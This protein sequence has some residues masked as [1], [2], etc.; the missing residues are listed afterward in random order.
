MG[1]HIW[2]PIVRKRYTRI[3]KYH[4]ALAFALLSGGAGSV[5]AQ[6]LPV[7]RVTG[8][9][10]RIT[11]SCRLEIAPD[12]VIADADGNGVIL[13]EANDITVDFADSV[14]RGAD[15]STPWNELT[16]TGVRLDG[17]S[18]VTIRN[19]NVH[20]FKVGVY[21]SKADGLVFEQADLSDNYRAHLGS[22]PERE[23]SSDW[24][25]PHHNE[26]NQWM[27]N[28]GAALYVEESDGITV[29]NVRVRRGQ[30]GIVLDTVAN[31]KVYDNDCSFLSGWGL[32]LWRATGNT[33]TRNAFDFCVRGHVEGVYNRGQ[34][35][36][37]ILMF[38]QVSNNVIA[39][40]SVTHG[41]DGIFGFAGLDA[42]GEQA[43]NRQR[44]RLR[45]E[46]GEQ[47]VDDKI[48][49]SDEVLEA[50]TR[51]GCNGNIF[52]END[53]SYA[54]AHGLEMTFSF[55]N[56]IFRNRFVENA[57]C[58]IWGGFSQ[59][60]LIYENLFDGNGGMAYGLERGG[61]NIEHSA[62][63]MILGNQFT[64]NRAAIHIWWDGLGDFG[65]LPWAKTS[66][67]GVLNNVI[68]DNTFTIN[69]EPRPFY[70][71]GQN[72]KRLAF[73]FRNDGGPFKGTLITNNTFKIDESVGKKMET[74]GDVEILDNGPVPAVQ[75]PSYTVLG[76]SRPVEVRNGVPYSTRSKL[77]GRD[78]IIMDE[79]GPWDHE[80]PLVRQLTKGGGE[81]VYDVLGVSGD[82]KAEAQG[83]GYTVRVEPGKID[84]SQRVVISVDEGVVPYSVHLTGDGLDRT[85]SG[86]T[87]KARWL[88]RAFSWKDKVDPREDFDAWTRLARASDS[89]PF[90]CDSLNLKFSFGGPKDLVNSGEINDTSGHLAQSDIGS[91]YFGIEAVGRLRMPKGTWRVRTV[92]DDGIR[93][94]AMT[95]G[96]GNDLVID[97]WTWHAPTP[98]EGTFTV[99]KD[100]DLV[101]MR[102]YHFEIDGMSMLT[103]DLER[104][105]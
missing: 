31:S 66:Y 36:A 3:M 102:V 61:V 41:G 98:N 87:I 23:D 77:R 50:H 71:L 39:Q 17:H 37:G 97:N 54:P 59:D 42:L 5:Y 72:E 88:A 70:R 74:S 101:V 44:D 94:Y 26:D 86:T 51:A 19:A 28:Y 20:G 75:V 16:G 18:N 78:Q 30:N 35:S 60:S 14:L 93:V 1:P 29:R 56:V 47:N 34:D 82:I 10:T 103:L 83:S 73:H 99:E 96:G 21:A 69:D 89:R 81:V 95:G 76:E 58:G 65:S 62:G 57:I 33:I 27:N 100:N 52:A 12:A 49:Y 32:A 25:F 38:E 64:N 22:T 79:W 84:N 13:I 55:D 45:R 48:A 9:N 43:R 85:L 90:S 7:V 6:S 91:D 4:S 80:S 105:D 15:K 40:N 24:L 8:D 67:R 68:A 2:K 63:N 11:Q 92:S 104:V 46:T 53:L